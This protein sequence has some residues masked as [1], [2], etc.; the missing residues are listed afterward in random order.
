MPALFDA[1]C[2]LQDPRIAADVEGMLR[3]AKAAGV[4]YLVCCGT[5]PA[6]WVRVLQLAKRFPQVIPMIGLHPWRA[7]AA[8]TGWAVLLRQL[9]RAHRVGIGECG[10]DFA[11]P[12][13][14]ASQEE[15]FRQHLRLARELNRPVALHCVKAWERFV[16][17]LRE[18]GLPEAG[19]LVHSYSGSAETAALLQDLG[20]HLSFSGSVVR[21]GNRK[22]PLILPQVRAER[23]LV[24]SDAPDQATGGVGLNEPARITA[25]IQ[26]V[27]RFREESETQVME[28]ASANGERLFKEW[29]A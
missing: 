12:G 6:D 2:H 4:T 9:A 29:I 27:A 16:T 14:R 20:L 24:E 3:R 19:G 23:L 5:E 7:A 25:V 28:T 15:A 1:H 26:A 17:V 18:E 10:L 22:A 11:I 8:P 21:P 13:D